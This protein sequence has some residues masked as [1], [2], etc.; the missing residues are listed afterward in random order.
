MLL[1]CFSQETGRLGR[2]EGEGEGEGRVRR[3]CMRVR[4][5]ERVQRDKILRDERVV[6]QKL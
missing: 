3:G 5:R 4:V 2:R 1:T 6:C